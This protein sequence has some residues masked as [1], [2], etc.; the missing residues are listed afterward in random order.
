MRLIP[1][2]QI[3][4]WLL[5]AVV[6]GQAQ[7]T[8][9]KTRILFLLD[10]SSSMTLAWND[11]NSRYD[12]ASRM[13]LQLIDSVYAVNNEV[14]FAVR[15]VG[16]QYPAQDKNCQ[17]TRL[18]VPFN[19]QNV[20][21]IKT[22]MFD[23]QPIG[24]SPIA[25]SLRTAADNELNNP[26]LYDYSI[27]FITD[28][29]ESCGGDVCETFKR[30][31]AGRMKVKPYVIGL[32]KNEQLQDIY[33]CL[34]NY[35]DVT[36]PDDIAQAIKIIVDANRLIIDKP[37][38]YNLNTFYSNVPPII[39]AD[40]VKID[41]TK[42][43]RKPFD[44]FLL[45]SFLPVLKREQ[46][47]I[48]A[49]KKT[50]PS[51]KAVVFKF[52]PE[53]P[54]IPIE[55]MVKRVIDVFPKLPLHRIV[56]APGKLKIEKGKQYVSVMP[57]VTFF[58][59]Q[60]V[61]RETQFL[62][63]LAQLN[64]RLPNV[65]RNSIKA[66]KMRPGPRKVTLDFP[67]ERPPADSIPRLWASKLAFPARIP[68]R[69]TAKT[70]NSKQA[71]VKLVFESDRPEPTIWPTLRY[72][73]F[74]MRYSYAFRL[75]EK[76]TISDRPAITLKFEIDKPP[77]KDS[78]VKKVTPPLQNGDLD[79]TVVTENSEQTQVQVYFK[80]PNGKAYLNAKPEIEFRELGTNTL[81]HSFRRLVN[82][83]EPVPQLVNQ[84]NY[85]VVVTGYTDLY[86]RNVTIQPNKINKVYINVTDG[87]LTFA[88]IGNR[89]RGMEFNAVVNRRFANDPTIIQKC[90]DRRN[91]DPGTYY[92][93]ITTLPVSKFSIELTFGAVYEIQIPEPGNLQ[94]TNTKPI[95]LIQ[96]QSVLGDGYATF[97]TMT[98]NGNT[99]NQQLTLQPG[100]YK[101]IVPINPS[102]PQ[103]G[104]KEIHFRV[105]SNKIT[106]LEIQ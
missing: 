82:N 39:Q 7:S 49:I 8:N 59:E 103:L 12:I 70:I 68:V 86:A 43:V 79:F 99:S 37:K 48:K 98:V 35:V 28:G 11:A 95:G 94:I 18:E 17:D 47:L 88:Y 58:F 74:P 5:L 81:K 55:P 15:S 102:V 80:G 2:A 77:K 50:Y 75:P 42:V 44:A 32:N 22:R 64:Y 57:K 23:L 46:I 25:Y 90:T 14:E 10:G 89:N 20:N 91:Y 6:G 93:E 4:C 45:P 36:E 19:L 16:T 27:I 13:L 104:T 31:L 30:F 78:V 101:A 69:L 62:P 63:S 84:G 60:V 97:K 72:I 29:G 85:N 54:S 71:P 41:N 105:Q 96:L 52:D 21:Q 1:I 92:V 100:P 38:Q 24:Y 76:M 53:I 40:P 83:G 65:E 106:Q 87:T 56:Q 73:K 67:I 33:Q 3:L 66:V 34:G 26:Q 9:K 61:Q 51:Q